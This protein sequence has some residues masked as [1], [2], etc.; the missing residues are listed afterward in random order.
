MAS[1]EETVQSIRKVSGTRRCRHEI[2][3]TKGSG[4]NRFSKE[5]IEAIRTSGL[6]DADWYLR[7]YP[8]VKALGMDP[9]EHYLWLGARLGRD[10]SEIF[11]SR[12]YLDLNEDVAA[13]GIDPLL[14][15]VKFGLKEGRFPRSSELPT[16]QLAAVPRFRQ[17]AVANQD[18]SLARGPEFAKSWPDV[19]RIARFFS[20]AEIANDLERIPEALIE[21]SG[22]IIDSA[23]IKPTVSVVIPT[24]NRRDTVGNAIR[25]AMRQYSKP[26][27]IIISDDGSTDGTIGFLNSN[28]RGEINSGFIKIIGNKHGGVSAARNA[29]LMIAS[30]DLIAYLDSD[31]SWR[32][33]YLLVMSAAFA[34][35]EHLYT[36]YAALKSHNISTGQTNFRASN[37]DRT[38]LLKG[39]FIDLNVFMHRRALFDQLG[40]FDERL[41][42]LVDWDVILRYTKLFEP[43]YLP[44]CAV[45]YYLDRDNLK[46]IT[47]TEGLEKNYRRIARKNFQ[48]RIR[49][50]ID[51]LKIGYFVFDFPAL[52]QTFVLNELRWLKENGYDVKVFYARDP[53]RK[54]VLDFSIDAIQVGDAHALA[55]ALIETGRNIC[56]SH[57]AYPGVT[58]FVQP[59]CELAEVNYTYMPHAVDIFHHKNRD[60]SRLEKISNDERC[61]R[62]FVYGDHH[63]RFL[64]AKGVDRHKISYNFQ[65]IEEEDFR[66]ACPPRVT[67]ERRSWRGVVIAR[68]IEKKGIGYLIEAAAHLHDLP[69]SFV[70]YGYGSL[71]ESYRRRVLELGLTNIEFPGAIEGREELAKAYTD[72]DFVVVPSVEASD[73]D[74]DGFPTVILEAMAAEK[75][76]ITTAVSAV[77][78]YLRDGIEALVAQPRDPNSLAAAIRRLFAMSEAERA[79]LIAGARQ[80]L[81]A[82]VGADNT[83]RRLLDIWQ[84]HEIEIFTVTYN[85]EK[86]DSKDDTIEIIRRILEKTTTRFSLTIVDNGSESEFICAIKELIAG[87]HNVRL[88]ENRKNVYCGPA[89]NQALSY[90]NAEFAIYVC[91]KEG[92]IKDHGWE[93][94]IIERMRANPDYAIAG[95]KT[96]LPK[97]TLGR[98]MVRHPQFPKFRNQ[99]FAHSNPHRALSHVQGGVYAIRRDTLVKHGWFSDQLTQDLMDVEYSYF[100]E[101]RGAVTGEIDEIKSISAKTLPRLTAV[102][103]EGTVI[104]HPLSAKTVASVLDVANS[105]GK[106]RCNLCGQVHEKDEISFADPARVVLCGSCGSTPF[107]RAIVA[108]I[109]HDHRTHRGKSA[110]LLGRD[111]GLRRFLEDRLYGLSTAAD[112]KAFEK[113]DQK[114]TTV[115]ADLDVAYAN[116]QFQLTSKVID[117]LEPDGLALIGG[118]SVRELA[119][120]P[121]IAKRLRERG[122]RASIHKKSSQFLASDWRPIMTIKPAYALSGDLK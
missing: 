40:G 47:F 68:F 88:I 118:Q 24:Y 115:I 2:G 91:S 95:Y 83:I 26:H 43:M 55:Q 59:A 41:T 51:T 5:D 85:T 105:R 22:E 20:E 102:V 32:P 28:F 93:R 3:S 54:A 48:D 9:I 103:D 57:F 122:F 64:E 65:A 97:A 34:E 72:A 11:N 60:R 56:H 75:P 42:R 18:I 104:A 82:R 46:N 19:S 30:G 74:I 45:D 23:K 63:R 111:T 107:G 25:S 33:E 73:G 90:G 70:V 6:F 96:H 8:D 87:W 77:P 10:P 81:K 92:F 62:V 101:S 98:E 17:S 52:S 120:D 99:H 76:V 117:A 61:L 113:G 12:R 58:L 116:M 44:F 53:E 100:L 86:Y 21:I 114:F 50:G 66:V 78:D 4:V 121:L 108:F 119:A 69:V 31:N 14:H 39:N 106:W 27:E 49:N 71:E 37:F 7:T 38:Q 84:G 13:A 110:A 80:F 1:P 35:C 94:A 15:Y 79:E 16:P 112:F 36:A 89:S 109:A 67:P 29:G